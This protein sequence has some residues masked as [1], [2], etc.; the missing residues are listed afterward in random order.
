MGTE[1]RS[2]P[3]LYRLPD[4]LTSLSLRFLVC[5]W[6]LEHTPHRTAGEMA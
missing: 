3:P 4:D 1:T 5:K 2:K 6:G